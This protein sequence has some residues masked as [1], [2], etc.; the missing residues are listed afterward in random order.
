VIDVGRLAVNGPFHWD[1]RPEPGLSIY[2]D[3][4]DAKSPSQQKLKAA[5]D[6]RGT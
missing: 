1:E 3:A 6:L 2:V 5:I 4:F